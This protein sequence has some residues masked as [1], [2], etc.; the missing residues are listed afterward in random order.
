MKNVN[1]KKSLIL[2]YTLVGDNEDLSCK[3]KFILNKLF[4]K[5]I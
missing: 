1:K 3:I 4:K 5:I 2:K